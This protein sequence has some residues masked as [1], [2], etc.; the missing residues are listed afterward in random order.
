MGSHHKDKMVSP[1]TEASSSHTS[2]L[3]SENLYT[4]T[5]GHFSL[6]WN[7]T[8]LLVDPCEPQCWIIVL[9]C[10]VPLHLPPRETL[11]KNTLRVICISKILGSFKNIVRYYCQMCN[12][13]RTKFKKLNVSHLVLQL[14]LPNLLKSCIKLRMK[15][16]LEQRRQAMPQLHLSDRQFNCPQSCTLY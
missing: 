8:L 16:W 3:Y 4:W 15:M 14:S 7:W 13:S 2:Y 11:Y 12:I 9:N 5:D 6:Y 10:N 1:P